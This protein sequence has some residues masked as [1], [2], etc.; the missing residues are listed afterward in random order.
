M[1]ALPSYITRLVRSSYVHATV[2]L[3]YSHMVAESKSDVSPGILQELEWYH[4]EGRSAFNAKNYGSACRLFEQALAGRER[5]LGSDIDETDNTRTFYAQSLFMA[6]KFKQA[7]EQLY[8]AVGFSERKH[9]RDH[10]ETLKRRMSLGEALERCGSGSLPD[11]SEQFRLAAVGWEST[12][13]QHTEDA[14]YCRYKAGLGYSSGEKFLLTWPYWKEGEDNLQ[15]ATEGWKR[16]YSEKDDK[17]L[18]AQI[19]YATVLLKKQDDSKAL[20]VFR[21][22]RDVAKRK[23]GPKSHAQ[24]IDI[25]E[26]I[27]ECKFWLSK[28]Q[29]RDRLEISRRREA[30]AK[31]KKDWRNE[32]GHW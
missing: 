21:S 5:L 7:E 30:K 28:G 10:P 4:Q 26:G 20:I 31:R 32:G 6:G 25:E 8:A 15:R 24:L 13:G 1:H 18:E 23:S 14:V 3:R 12:V 19:A 29:P 27:E 17:A 11:A 22:A 2:N 16:L 9:G